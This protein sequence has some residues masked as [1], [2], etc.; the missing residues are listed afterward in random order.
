MW[1]PICC[2]EHDVI[3]SGYEFGDRSR[4]VDYEGLRWVSVTL[5]TLELRGVAAKNPMKLIAV[6]R[7]TC[8]DE[9]VD[10]DGLFVTDEGYHADAQRLAP[11]VLAVFGLLH[12]GGN[13][14]SDVRA[15]WRLTLPSRLEPDTRCAMVCGRRWTRLASRRG[16]M[17]PS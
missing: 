11:V 13:E 5:I 16:L 4:V 2:S 7:N 12:G 8:V 17:R 15:S 6:R 10:F 14:R 9:V 1:S 3:G